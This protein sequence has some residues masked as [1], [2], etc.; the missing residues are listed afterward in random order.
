VFVSLLYLRPLELELTHAFYVLQV[1]VSVQYSDTMLFGYVGCAITPLHVQNLVTAAG[2]IYSSEDDTA[3][4]LSSGLLRFGVSQSTP[5]PG[6]LAV[7]PKTGTLSGTATSA[8][9]RKS[10][11][12]KP[13]TVTISVCAP[14]AL[15]PATTVS[16]SI[17]ID[18]YASKLVREAFFPDA[19]DS[20]AP[21]FDTELV[22]VF[23]FYNQ[24][25]QTILNQVK[26]EF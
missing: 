20:K 11:G 8:F 21:M 24:Q 4:L 9:H 2:D 16:I 17:R 25:L 19:E 10:G 1:V 13:V 18:P 26:H 5:L 12:A 15:K 7:D 22:S 3:V 14:L 6:G 23:D